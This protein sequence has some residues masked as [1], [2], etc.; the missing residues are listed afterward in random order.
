[1]SAR[2]IYRWRSNAARQYARGHLIAIGVT[3]DEARARIR[4]H[5]R[6]WIASDDG[7]PHLDGHDD[8][9]RVQIAEFLSVLDND[10]LATPEVSDALVIWGSE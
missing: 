9:D 4:I 6:K 8:D 10:L 7:K 3:P 1:M 5:A 2:H